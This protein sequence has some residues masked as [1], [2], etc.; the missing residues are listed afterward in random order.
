MDYIPNWGLGISESGEAESESK[1]SISD[2]INIPN[3]KFEAPNWGYY[4]QLVILYPIGFNI[5]LVYI[6]ALQSL[7]VH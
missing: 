4:T 7:A 2:G 1:S 5:L 3:W 6:T